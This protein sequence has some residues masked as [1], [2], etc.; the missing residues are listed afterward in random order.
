[1]TRTGEYVHQDDGVYP[2]SIAITLH[3]NP[4]PE[5]SS[6]LLLGTGLLGLAGVAFRKVKLAR[7]V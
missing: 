4:T 1:M 6:L 7:G 2:A 3:A 5:P